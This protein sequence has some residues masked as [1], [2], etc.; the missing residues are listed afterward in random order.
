MLSILNLTVDVY[1]YWHVFGLKK[2]NEVHPN[3]KPNEVKQKAL[4]LT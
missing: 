2:K 4:G 3:V 1:T